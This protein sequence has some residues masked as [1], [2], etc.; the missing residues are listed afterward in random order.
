MIFDLG[1]TLVDETRNW[2][3]WAEHLGVPTLTLF[4]MMGAVVSERRPQTDAFELIRPGFDF[5]A[6]RDLIDA[7]GST[8]SVGPEDLYPDALPALAELRDAGFRIAVMAN[9][10]KLVESFL[11]ELPIDLF[12]TSAGWGVAKPD[13][14]FFDRVIQEVGVPAEAIAYVG[15]RIDNDVLPAQAAG[16]V[17]V[18]IRRGPW[19][20]IQS[21]WPEA[22]RADLRIEGLAGLPAALA[23]L[24]QPA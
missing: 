24:S 21:Q 6:E 10:P 12:G 22:K 16:M 11:S 14:R 17:G 3:K 23:A 18:H 15:D 4:A 20:I 9:Q 19:G 2:A 7:T 5:I 8:W 13:P 1:E